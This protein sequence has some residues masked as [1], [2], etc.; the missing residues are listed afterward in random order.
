MK[1]SVKI[2]GPVEGKKG[3]YHAEGK[4]PSN[5]KVSVIVWEKP[6]NNFLIITLKNHHS[7]IDNKR[8]VSYAGGILTK[9]KSNK[10]GTVLTFENLS[11]T[12]RRDR[13]KEKEESSSQI[14]E[15]QAQIQELLG[16]VREQKDT[17]TD[18]VANQNK[19]PDTTKEISDLKAVVLKQQEE[20]KA[21]QSQQASPKKEEASK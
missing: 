12:L 16:L 17:I 1:F 19:Q 5:G 6:D 14:A 7:F 9:G 15:Q 21:L 11:Y 3:F 10:S 8:V 2:S 18:L 13:K 20:I 4:S